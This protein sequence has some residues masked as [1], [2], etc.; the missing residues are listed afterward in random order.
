VTGVPE[1][2]IFLSVAVHNK[3]L[4]SQ[5]NLLAQIEQVQDKI[6]HVLYDHDIINLNNLSADIL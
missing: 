1:K 4:S 2:A 6:K 5:C 3:H